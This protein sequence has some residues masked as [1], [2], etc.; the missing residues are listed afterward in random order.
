[1]S[2]SKHKL[3]WL[4]SVTSLLAVATCYSTLA[5][6]SLLSLIGVSVDIDEA[7]L[8]K[9]IT[10]LL[11]LALA[12][13]LYSWRSHR[14]PGPLILSLGAAVLLLWVFYGSYSKPLELTGF[15]LL[16]IASIWDFRA[17][18]R[19]CTEQCHGENT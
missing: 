14:H 17:R 8:V 16:V 13:M 3:S 18:K 11:I 7:V 5:A 19:V 15:A 6:V 1:M 2:K 4:G 12:G 9:L 10:G